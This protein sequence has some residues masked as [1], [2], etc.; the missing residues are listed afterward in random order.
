M[1]RLLP[2]FV[3]GLLVPIAAAH[4]TERAPSHKAAS[5]ELSV[6]H[7]EIVLPTI[8]RASAAG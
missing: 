8:G 5:D 3:L 2:T 7:A 6:E 4:A 1:M